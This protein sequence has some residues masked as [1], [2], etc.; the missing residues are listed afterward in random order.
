MSMSDGAASLLAAGVH[1]ADEGAECLE[2][3]GVWDEG[4]EMRDSTKLGGLS[5]T[6][7]GPPEHERVMTRSGPWGV[8]RMRSRRGRAGESNESSREAVGKRRGN[9][10]VELGRS[11]ALSCP[12]G[13]ALRGKS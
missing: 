8:T 4:G 5:L 11:T 7:T 2:R 1:A 13:M 12:E 10:G 9:V 3:Q 6:S